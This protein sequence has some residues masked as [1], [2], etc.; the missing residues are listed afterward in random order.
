MANGHG[1]ARPGAGRKR[2]PLPSKLV[3]DAIEL[4]EKLIEDGD[5]D[6]V[7][8]VLDRAYPVMKATKLPDV[9]EPMRDTTARLAYG[10]TSSATFSQLGNVAL[11]AMREVY[12]SSS[13][14]LREVEVE[15]V[16]PLSSWH[17]AWLV[18]TYDNVNYCVV[19]V[20]EDGGF[21][22]DEAFGSKRQ[23]LDFFISIKD[24]EC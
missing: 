3:D 12:V 7:K 4:V 21:V 5:K 20:A 15:Q 6:A 2:K 16:A 22:I 23:A 14:A 17:P 19:C 9:P 18:L 11:Y 13:N 8:L 1:G 10:F 24:Y